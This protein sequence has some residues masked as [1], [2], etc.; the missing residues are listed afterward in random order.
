MVNATEKRREEDSDEMER[1]T[2]EKIESV[3]HSSKIE[4][5]MKMEEQSKH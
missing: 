1:R 4:I 3:V 2:A 5:E